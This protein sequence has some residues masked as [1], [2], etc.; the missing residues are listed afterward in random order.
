M[1]SPLVWLRTVSPSTYLTPTPQLFMLLSLTSCQV[2][3][4]SPLEVQCVPVCENV[5]VFV[6]VC[7]SVVLV[8]LG[9]CDGRFLNR[10]M[11]CQTQQTVWFFSL[12]LD[13]ISSFLSTSDWGLGSTIHEVETYRTYAQ[14]LSCLI[15]LSIFQ[16]VLGE[17]KFSNPLNSMSLRFIS[18]F[19]TKDC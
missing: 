11:A 10:L 2:V 15:W 17:T 7:L 8:C 5:C 1:F 9:L 4:Y 14:G 16:N 6:C 13:E 3:L 18:G 19:I 12:S